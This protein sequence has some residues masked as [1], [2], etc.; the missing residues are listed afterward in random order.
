MKER[1]SN[2]N[3]TSC[4][5]F[6][7]GKS[8]IFADRQICEDKDIDLRKKKKWV[9]LH[10]SILTICA[11]SEG[12][13]CLWE[14]LY[15]DAAPAWRVV[16]PRKGV[17]RNSRWASRVV[18]MP[19]PHWLCEL[20]SL[21]SRCCQKIS[22]FPFCFQ[23]ELFKLGSS[24]EQSF[25]GAPGPF[26]ICVCFPAPSQMHLW[27]FSHSPCLLCLPQSVR[28]VPTWLSQRL[29]CLL[30]GDF[31]CFNWGASKIVA[32]YEAKGFSLALG[33]FLST[34]KHVLQ[35]FL[36]NDRWYYSSQSSSCFKMPQMICLCCSDS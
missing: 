27:S 9:C 7:S 15:S 34:C 28:V 3:Y 16:Q 17:P 18:L 20:G 36:L 22:V 10:W 11:F 24:S 21:G 5:M 31:K 25:S 33:T 8:C 32:F 14:G 23:P 13:I 35:F 1:G 30:W 2:V 6:S 29:L 19:C 12:E 4:S 26:Q